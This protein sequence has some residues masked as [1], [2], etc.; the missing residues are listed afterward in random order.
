MHVLSKVVSRPCCHAPLFSPVW[1]W[2][3]FYTN[4]SN[5]GRLAQIRAY[6][7]TYLYYGINIVRRARVRPR[8]DMTCRVFDPACFLT[9]HTDIVHNNGAEYHNTRCIGLICTRYI[10]NHTGITPV[11]RISNRRKI[12]AY[13][14]QNPGIGGRSRKNGC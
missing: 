11:K 9:L 14:A 10:G 8:S 2:E 4:T 3:Q 12:S 6:I 1:P 5:F 13:G 7:C